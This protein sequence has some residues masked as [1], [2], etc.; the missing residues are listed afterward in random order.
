MSYGFNINRYG[1]LLAGQSLFHQSREQP[2][3]PGQHLADMIALVGEVPSS[4]TERDR[5]MRR[6][7]WPPE[8]VNANGKLC[9]SVAEF[10]DGTFF[11]R[12]R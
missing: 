9:K 5:E 10:Y 4:V 1:A 6:W 3:S 8:V 12:R 2:Y 11:L 7:R